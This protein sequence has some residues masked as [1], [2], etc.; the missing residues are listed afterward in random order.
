MTAEAGGRM[1]EAGYEHWNSPNTNATNQSG[2][3]ALP[4]GYRINPGYSQLGYE[5]PFWSSSECG[6]CWDGI[7]YSWRRVLY[8]ND[9]IVL[10]DDG[11]KNNGYSV[12]CLKD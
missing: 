11:D 6:E 4:G 2:F 12:R 1:K 5:V 10:R 3:T 8:Y 7:N 9:N